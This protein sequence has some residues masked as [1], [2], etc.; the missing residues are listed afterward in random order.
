VILS[1]VGTT[2][3]KVSHNGSSSISIMGTS[4]KPSDL[5]VAPGGSQT[6]AAGGVTSFTL[7]SKKTIGVY[8]VTF[9]S[10][11]GSKTIPVTVIL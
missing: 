6:V 3:V 7:K 4:S 9:S 11:C 1:R 10:G 8:S 2:S 5:Q